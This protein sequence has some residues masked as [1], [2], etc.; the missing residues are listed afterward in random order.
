MF[1]FQDLFGVW[2][3]KTCWQTFAAD[4]RAT[5]TCRRKRRKKSSGS[6]VRGNDSRKKRR[7]PRMRQ[8]RVRFS[9]SCPTT[10]KSRWT[11]TRTTGNV[12]E[13]RCSGFRQFFRLIRTKT[14]TMQTAT[15]MTTTKRKMRTTSRDRLFRRQKKRLRRVVRIQILTLNRQDKTGEK[16]DKP[17][18]KTMSNK[19]FRQQLWHR[20]VQRRRLASRRPD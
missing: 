1:V 9:S 20:K 7:L 19:S 17:R 12:W 2:T 13:K 14:P 11:D 18:P 10:S 16:P 4:E 6:T 5:T 8:T 15:T 3:P